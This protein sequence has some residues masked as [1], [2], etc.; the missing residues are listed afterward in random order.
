MHIVEM[1]H[2]EL[3][4]LFM[5][6]LLEPLIVVL[7]LHSLELLILVELL[8]LDFL[9]DKLLALCS[10]MAPGA[11]FILLWLSSQGLSTA[12]ITCGWL[13]T[14]AHV[15][16]APQDYIPPGTAIGKYKQGSAAGSEDGESTTKAAM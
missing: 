11:I 12:Y 15:L 4:E 16:L 8:L 9:R 5:S 2:T 7:L 6:E 3:I 10:P 1:L 14:C 13:D